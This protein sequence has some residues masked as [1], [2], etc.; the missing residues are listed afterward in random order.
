MRG[1]EVERVLVLNLKPWCRRLCFHTNR[2]LTLRE[3]LILK[4]GTV[5]PYSTSAGR[6]CTTILFTHLDELR[7]LKWEL[8]QNATNTFILTKILE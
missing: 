1:V 7:T 3:L 2:V 5:A 4:Q 8:K 6:V